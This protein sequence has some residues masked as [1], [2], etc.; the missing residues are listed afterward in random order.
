MAKNEQKQTTDELLQDI[1]IIQ[2]A[3]S[4]LT[5][6]QIREIVG[7]HINR[8]NRIAK[9]FKKAGKHEK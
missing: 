7:V 4:G 1:M 5:Q 2:L 3:Q 6:H 9:Y 8:V